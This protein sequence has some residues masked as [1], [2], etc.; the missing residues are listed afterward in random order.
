MSR[1]RGKPPSQRQLRVG[2]ELRHVLAQVLADGQVHDPDLLQANITVTEVRIS[3]DLKNATAFVLPLG[4]RGKDATVAALRRAAPFLR[5][6]LAETANLRFTPRLSF[7]LDLTFDEAERVDSLLRRARVTRD[8]EA[9][10]EGD[11]G[12]TS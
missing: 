1:S 2:E 3:P 11:D 5:H 7:Q 10:D 12:T 9:G 8:L 4:G 6:R